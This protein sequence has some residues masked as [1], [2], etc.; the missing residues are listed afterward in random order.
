MIRYDLDSQG[1]VPIGL[2]DSDWGGQKVECFS[3][4]DALVGPGK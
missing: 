3:S 1:E 4:P 2:V